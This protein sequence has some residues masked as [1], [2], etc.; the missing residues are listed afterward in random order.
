MRLCRFR[1]LADDLAAT[2]ESSTRAN[3]SSQTPPEPVITDTTFKSLAAWV[4]HGSG[5]DDG[6]ISPASLDLEP[7]RTSAETNASHTVL[8][9]LMSTSRTML[10]I[11][12]Q[13]YVRSG[14]LNLPLISVPPP[15]CLPSAVNSHHK[16]ASD[17]SVSSRPCPSSKAVHHLV[18]TCHI[19]LTSVY[20]SVLKTLEQ[21]TRLGQ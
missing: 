11:L 16:K 1:R 12:R 21:H 7:Q 2:T 9:H 15:T 8:Y 19:V 14:P 20:V 13:L 18:I 6:S 10:E 5:Q 4:S 17:I 3:L